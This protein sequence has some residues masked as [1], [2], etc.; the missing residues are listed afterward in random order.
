M[1]CWRE[2]NA[3]RTSDDTEVLR[4]RLELIAEALETAVRREVRR[5]RERGLP[6]YVARNSGIV[7]LSASSAPGGPDHPA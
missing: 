6:V 7:D 4:K 5:L 2:P 1:R 3:A